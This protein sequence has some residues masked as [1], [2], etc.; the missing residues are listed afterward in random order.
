MELT[1]N[2]EHIKSTY[3]CGKSTYTCGNSQ[4]DSRATKAIRKIRRQLGSKGRKQLHQDLCP[5][6]GTQKKRE[7]TQRGEGWIY[8]CSGEGVV[9]VTNW[10]PQ[11]WGPTQ[12]RPAPVAVQR[13]A[14]TNRRAV[15][16][17]NCAC[18]ESSSQ[19]CTWGR[20]QRALLQGLLGFLWLAALLCSLSWETE[21]AF[22]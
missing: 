6:E 4:K 12:G 11:F 15:G 8:T 3:T 22:S 20:V 19:V 9:K 14:E 18:E 10:I 16:S 21:L 13:T 1:S 2:H 5:W 7:I 17:L